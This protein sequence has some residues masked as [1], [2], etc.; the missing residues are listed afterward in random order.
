MNGYVLGLDLGTSSLKALLLRDDGA[1]TASASRGY[2]ITAPQPGYA[3]QSPD[4]WWT[5]LC[6]ATRAV[7]A[8]AGVQ[9]SAVHAIGLSGQMHGTVCLG[10][11][12]RLLRPA[13]IWSDH[14]SV[15]EAAQAD[16][17][18]S[19]KG[20]TARLGGGV[21]PGFMA[22]TLLWLR[23][24]EQDVW[25]RLRTVLLPKDYLRWR[26]AGELGT[27]PSDACGTPL[28]D[29]QAGQWSRTAC[30][31]LDLRAELFP[32]IA[33]SHAVRGGL[34][35]AAAL[36]MGLR[37]GT[38]VVS[39]CS[40]QAAAALGVGL[41]APGALLVSFS[42]GGQVLACTPTPLAR[43]AL[44]ARTLLHAVPDAY[45]AL[46]ATLSAGLSL[47]WLSSWLAADGPGRPGGAPHALLA[48]ANTAPPGA[49]G[50]LFLPY[51][52]GERAP[53]ADPLAAGAL[54]GLTLE[55]DR[56]HLARAVVEGVVFSLRHA[57]GLLH[58]AGIESNRIIFSGGLSGDPLLQRIVADVFGLPTTPAPTS[59][60]SALGAA[61]LAGVGAGWYADPAT[62]GRTVLAHDDDPI[63]P[64][65][66]RAALYDAYYERYRGLYRTLRDDMHAL[67]AAAARTIVDNAL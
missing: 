17:I 25:S 3:E 12:A 30:D 9:D 14:R 57:A 32:P 52:S 34:T 48:L 36:E 22:A 21:A 44:G 33:P 15:E 31:A 51:L 13:I 7:L 27:D 42:S 45:L 38:P 11:S 62:A 4:T 41:V 61:L 6:E 1:I 35:A 59:A 58:E 47:Q 55:H 18:L 40:D 23:A 50:L 54:I 2:A 29:I 66:R 19:Q 56:A 39:G 5:A 20:L 49:G 24:H 28:Y 8:Q 60:H 37:P 53:I 10:S 64:D 65:E 46:S 43:P 63:V 67:R 26:L 16:H